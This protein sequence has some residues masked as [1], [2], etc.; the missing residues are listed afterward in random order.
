MF[1]LFIRLSILLEKVAKGLLISLVYLSVYFL[2]FVCH[3]PN[4]LTRLWNHWMIEDVRDL[5]VHLAQP[6]LK[7]DHP[8]LG[9]QSHVQVASSDLQAGNSTVSMG[10]PYQ[11][12]IRIAQKHIP[13]CRWN[14]LCPVPLVLTLGTTEKSLALTSLHLPFRY[15]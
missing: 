9:V 4:V 14:F 2:C 5:W 8:E 7:Q 1:N 10:N 12:T 15:L 11:C 6:L 3:L 13:I